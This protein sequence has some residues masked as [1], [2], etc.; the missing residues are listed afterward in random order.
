M[1][2]RDLA[3]RLAAELELAGKEDRVREAYHEMETGQL[4]AEDV[5]WAVLEALGRILGQTPAA[6]REMGRSFGPP[7]A[8]PGRRYAFGRTVAGAPVGETPVT[9]GETGTDREPDEVDYLFR[10]G[11]ED[12]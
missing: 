12:E 8:M 5:K 11:A 4:G 6:L 7:P 1:K 3:A 10:G 2:R 9:A